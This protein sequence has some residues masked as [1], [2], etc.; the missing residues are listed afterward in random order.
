MT[1][2][3]VPVS[4]AATEVGAQALGNA[5]TVGTMAL[6]CLILG[7]MFGIG[8]FTVLISPLEVYNDGTRTFV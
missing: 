6:P 8:R 1:G 7:L 3:R 4:L 2:L 5:A